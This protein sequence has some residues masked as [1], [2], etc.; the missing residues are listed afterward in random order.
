MPE[1]TIAGH[2]FTVP[3]PYAEGHILTANEAAALNQVFHENLRNNFAKK[4]KDLVEAG[5]DPQSLSDEFESYVNSYEFGVRRGGGGGGARNP[6]QTEAMNLARE[7]VKAAIRKQGRNPADY[8]GKQVS[9]LAEKLLAKNPT[10]R[11][12]AEER[13][14]S[15]REAADAVMADAAEAIESHDNPAPKTK[16]SKKAA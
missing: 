15:Q 1:I 13:V 11:E 16:R 5:G 4:V 2:P 3:A 14:R 6:V 9:D 8:S 12:L 10:F 7:A